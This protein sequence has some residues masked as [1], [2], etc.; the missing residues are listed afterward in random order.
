MLLELFFKDKARCEIAFWHI[1][2]PIPTAGTPYDFISRFIHKRFVV[3]YQLCGMP[4]FGRFYGSRG[5]YRGRRA[6]QKPPASL[7]RKRVH[8]RTGFTSKGQPCP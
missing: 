1:P 4:D 2:T 3:V 7:T 5:C 6:R 8:R